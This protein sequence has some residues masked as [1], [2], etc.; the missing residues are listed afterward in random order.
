M[1]NQAVFVSFLAQ[2]V[3]ICKRNGSFL[4]QKGLFLARNGTV[5]LE[6]VFFNRTVRFFHGKVPFVCNVK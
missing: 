4:S 2:C 5:N 1:V 6:C 3:S